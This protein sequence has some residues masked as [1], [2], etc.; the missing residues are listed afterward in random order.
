MIDGTGKAGKM[1]PT[2]SSPFPSNEFP[3]SL[4]PKLLLIHSWARTGLSSLLTKCRELG[5]PSPELLLN[6][7]RR[8]VESTL[9]RHPARVKGQAGR[10]RAKK[11]RA[12]PGLLKLYFTSWAPS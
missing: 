8:D 4:K 9:G 6:H 7:I 12:P 5:I 2:F 11:A 1:C 3:V 10:R